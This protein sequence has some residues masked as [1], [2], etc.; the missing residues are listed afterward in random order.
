LIGRWE[1]RAVL[2]LGLFFGSIGITSDGSL[3]VI[4]DMWTGFWSWGY[5]FGLISL[6][7][8]LGAVLAYDRTLRTGRRVWAAPLLG[9]LASAVHPW[10]G[11]TLILIVIGAEL[12]IG[13]DRVRWRRRLALPL[14]TIAAT[15]TPLAYYAILARTDLSWRLAQQSSHHSFLL[16]SILLALAPLLVFAAFAYRGRPRTFYTAATRV[17]PFAALA[18][19]VVS[20]SDLSG[21]PL[22]AFAG[23]TVPLAVLAVQG[24][25]RWDWK[26]V[27]RRRLLMALAVAAVTIPATVD[28]LA[29]APQFVA[30]TDGNAN[31]I[32]RGERHALEYLATT[33]KPGGV[34]TRFY[35]GTIVPAETGRRTYVGDCLWS[36][37][38]CTPRS[39]LVQQLLDGGLTARAARSF[40]L[41]TGARFVLADCESPA[42][43]ARLLRP[44]IRGVHSFGCATVYEVA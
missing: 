37:P 34:L 3:G 32:T 8:E 24:V 9:M 35:L 2:V 30:P 36:E 1:R 11:E 14:A 31:F 43:L 41:G 20:E 7:A 29:V 25:Q 21:T 38:D 42:D 5:P 33:R 6:A 27:P 17:W 23:V 22:H 19:Y 4:G 18:I 10:Q 13:I 40:V 16:V 44:I 15:V 26:R 28:E 12:V 39:Q